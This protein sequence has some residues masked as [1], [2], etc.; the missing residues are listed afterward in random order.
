MTLIMPHTHT[1]TGFRREFA[2]IIKCITIY[3]RVSCGVRYTTQAISYIGLLFNA[4]AVHPRR[5]RA[6]VSICERAE[7]TTNSGGGGVAPQMRQSAACGWVKEGRVCWF[8][9][10]M[11]SCLVSVHVVRCFRG[12]WEAC[13]CICASPAYNPGFVFM[14]K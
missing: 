12:G 1:R 5:V 2:E 9:R 11:L 4:T 10:Y 6:S 8:W 3:P 7:E 13:S 14:F